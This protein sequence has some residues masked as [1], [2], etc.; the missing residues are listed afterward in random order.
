MLNA[1][2]RFIGKCRFATGLVLDYN[3]KK[4]GFSEDN[5]YSKTYL[6]NIPLFN[7]YKRAQAWKIDDFNLKEISVVFSSF[8]NNFINHFVGLFLFFWL[9]FYSIYHFLSIFIY[10]FKNMNRFN[11]EKKHITFYGFGHLAF[12][13]FFEPIKFVLVLAFEHLEQVIGSF[14]KLFAYQLKLNIKILIQ[15]IEIALIP[16]IGVVFLIIKMVIKACSI[17]PVVFRLMFRKI[18]ISTN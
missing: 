15:I 13:I 12:S 3:Y 11:S 7:N 8:A 10:L 2:V 4:G 17:F 14:A 6:D 16:L 1:I 5:G 9:F 18:S